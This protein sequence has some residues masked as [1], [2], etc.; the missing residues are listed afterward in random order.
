MT[1]YNV[2]RHQCYDGFQQEFP[3]MWEESNAILKRSLR[4]SCKVI[5]QWE[6]VSKGSGN[7]GIFSALSDNI[8][9]LWE[10]NMARELPV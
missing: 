9:G 4:G 10:W 7:M 5:F 6:S 3:W 8:S 2:N 1:Q